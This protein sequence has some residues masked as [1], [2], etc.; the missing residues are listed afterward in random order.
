MD[1]A[2]FEERKTP[3][4]QAAGEGHPSFAGTRKRARVLAVVV[5]Y[6]PD[7]SLL[8]ALASYMQKEDDVDVLIVD[9]S[10][11]PAGRRTAAAVAQNLGVE[12]VLNPVNLGVAEAQNIGMRI[13]IER[14]YTYALLLDQDSC[15]EEGAIARLIAAHERLSGRGERVAAVGPVYFDARNGLGFP[16]VRL[17]R[18]RMKKLYP[19]ADDTEVQCDLLISSG[20]LVSLEAV[21]CIGVTDSSFFIDYVDF[22]WCTRARAAGFKVYGIPAARMTHRIGTGSFKLLGRMIVV[23]PPIRHYYLIRNA[24]L[25]ARKPYLSGRWRMHLVYRALAQ[26]L[27]FVVLSPKRAERTRWMMRGL[28]DGLRGRGGRLGGPS[29]IRPAPRDSL[30]GQQNS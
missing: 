2:S 7:A 14:G 24:L 1:L 16:F 12:C 30:V 13:G 28:F 21:R 20:C 27:L 25:F 3:R 10:E 23:H 26:I 19:D 8:G 18:L 29:G 22:E 17:N 11:T 9:N 15:F 5:S 4:T 6:E